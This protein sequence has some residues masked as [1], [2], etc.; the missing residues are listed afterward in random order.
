MQTAKMGIAALVCAALLT[1]PGCRPVSRADCLTRARL[2]AERQGSGALLGLKAG[3]FP[4][5][6]VLPDRSNPMTGVRLPGIPCQT[7]IWR[8]AQGRT[9]AQP[10]YLQQ[11]VRLTLGESGFYVGLVDDG[12]ALV[13]QQYP[14]GVTSTHTVFDA[15]G[16]IVYGICG[17]RTEEFLRE[18]HSPPQ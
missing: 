14:G 16:V 3:T 7:R 13:V 5:Q 9:M 4:G 8:D 6:I 11:P 17:S 1:L 15:S 2:A 10:S 12:T 18:C